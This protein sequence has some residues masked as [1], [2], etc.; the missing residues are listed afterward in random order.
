MEELYTDVPFVEQSADIL[1]SMEPKA[2]KNIC[3]RVMSRLVAGNVKPQLDNTEVNKVS[4]LLERELN[5]VEY[6]LTTIS[7]IFLKAA[8]YALKSHNFLNS[9]EYLSHFS[10]DGKSALHAAYEGQFQNLLA[11]LKKDSVFPS[12]YGF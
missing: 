10:D 4:K 1:G 8:S 12:R 5:E 2:V 7:T 9:L 11:A 6:L 3:D